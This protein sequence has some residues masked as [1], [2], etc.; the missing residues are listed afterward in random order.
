MVM[1]CG[2]QWVKVEAVQ[3]WTQFYRTDFRN[4]SDVTTTNPRDTH[5]TTILRFISKQ[6]FGLPTQSSG[7]PVLLPVDFGIICVPQ[8]L[9][10]APNRTSCTVPKPKMICIASQLSSQNCGGTKLGRSGCS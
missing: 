10:F 4:V 3:I 6:R 1:K 8:L 7:R 9:S 2:F 5:T